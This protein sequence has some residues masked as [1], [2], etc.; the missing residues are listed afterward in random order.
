M[1]PKPGEVFRIDGRA[2]VQFGGDRALIFRVSVVSKAPT[3]HGWI[4]LTGYVLDEKDRAVERREIFVQ[5]AGLRRLGSPVL[6]PAAV[7]ASSARRTGSPST[8]RQ[9]RV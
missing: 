5:R 9:Q 1:D 6:G 2:S 4:W 8:R 7:R 3:Y